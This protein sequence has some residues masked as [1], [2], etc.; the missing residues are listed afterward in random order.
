MNKTIKISVRNLIEFVLRSGDIDNSFMSTTRALEGTLAHQKVQKSYGHE[1]SPEVTL[2][3]SFSYGEY[4]LEIEGRADGIFKFP[5]E[6]II[7]E[8]KSTTRD[9]EDIEEDYNHLHW[10]QAKC[11][12]YIY[13]LQ[14]E[15]ENISIQ[16]SY[17]HIESEELKI[18][19]R[20]FS[21]VDL[22]IFFIDIIESY[23][24]WAKLTFD[25]TGIRDSTIL[26]MDFP[27]KNYR[28]G[29][30]EL[31]VAAYK[32][33]KEGKNLFAQAPTG[34]GK[35]MSTLFPSIKNV[36]EGSIS[37]IFYLTAKTI[38]REIPMKS[39]ELLMNNGLRAK[40][41]V[42][43]AKD[44]ICLNDEVKCNPRDCSYAKG[45]YDRVN[46][47]IMDLF[48]NED[49]ISRDIIISYANK[50]N[51]CPFEF[52]LD[53]S[54]WADVI[55]CDYNYV[56]DPQVSLKRFFDGL[57]RD[58]AFLIDESHN[59]VDRSR[60]MFSAEINKADFLD[61]KGIF[62]DKYPSLYKAM[63]KCNNIMNNLK[64]EIDK[65]S[66]YQREEIT[67]FYYPIKR[68]ITLM[69]P[70]LIGEKEHEDYERVMDFY[71]KLISFI[72]ISDL[73]DEHYVTSIEV[74]DRDMIIKLY[75]VDS[76]YLLNES[77]RKGKSGIFFS[78]TLT[79]L[80]YHMDL[81]GGNKDD[82]FIRLSS[83]FPRENLSLLIR[84]NI[85][86]R[87]KDREMTYLEIVESIEVFTLSK[88]G[89]YFVFFPSYA[90]MRH[91]YDI[92]LE[93]NPDFNITIQEGNMTEIQREEFLNRFNE[94]DDLIAFAVM[95]GIFSEGIDLVG[96]KLIGAV[97]IGVGLPQICFDRDII[98]DYFNG[99]QNLGFEY[100]YMYPGVTKILQS[101]GRVIRSEE[102][103][104]ALLLI[105][106]RFG[107]YRYKELFPREWSHY[108]FVKDNY[109]IKK[110]LELFW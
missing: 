57:T 96:D 84:D 20:S 92:F 86:T 12:A 40:T 37:K 31:A 24:K 43:T 46:D 3:H 5:E 59:L 101:A 23:I 66:Y 74:M 72:K 78:A 106:D 8:I 30:R 21:F 58:F 88:K 67:D 102:D 108:K 9:L 80:E 82:Y 10:A 83:P 35:T 29:Q 4:L 65:K 53:I 87:Y 41:L 22:E 26:D 60:E 104:G 79:P 70:W 62:K 85:S 95:G 49:M 103:R 55:I 34:I 63:N 50:H 68:I 19:R 45:H 2:K 100:A 93:R 28:K 54:L 11:Y 39:M 64:K 73:Y 107:T 91:V 1:Y 16:L 89:N 105:D 47:A 38:T 27:F 109:T 61:L 99:K 7:D 75:C 81:L 76:S 94:E 77:L 36:G 15:L 56:F 17:F 6:I 69:E 44:K 97:I 42:I 48:K 110:N 90:Y 52:S 33:I 51:V 32:S 71:F 18:F 14:N 13:A 98:K 25:W